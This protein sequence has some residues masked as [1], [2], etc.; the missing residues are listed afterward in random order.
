MSCPGMRLALVLAVP[1]EENPTHLVGPLVLVHLGAKLIP[2][3]PPLPLVPHPVR[4]LP[5]PK[6]P[7]PPLLSA[8]L[9]L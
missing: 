6:L 8:G 5:C 9:E 7:Q 1:L 2:K 4:D 3:P